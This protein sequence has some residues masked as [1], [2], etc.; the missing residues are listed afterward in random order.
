MRRLWIAFL[1][2]AAVPLAAPRALACKYHISL[3]CGYCHAPMGYFTGAGSMDMRVS[4]TVLV[5]G[6]SLSLD[7]GRG[8]R[9]SNFIGTVECNL[10][11]CR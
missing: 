11:G 5:H 2:A 4:D 7:A 10:V 8:R 1:L 9:L 6:R 3:F